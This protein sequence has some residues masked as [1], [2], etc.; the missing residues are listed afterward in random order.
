[1][2]F[3]YYRIVNSSCLASSG[4]VWTVFTSDLRI[5]LQSCRPILSSRCSIALLRLHHSVVLSREDGAEHVSRL[6][7]I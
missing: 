2:I 3:I 4:A 1:M 7:V 5:S 6:Y